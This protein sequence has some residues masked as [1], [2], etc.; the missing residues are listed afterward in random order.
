MHSLHLCILKCIYI[1]IRVSLV[2][3]R[4]WLNGWCTARRFQVQESAC[5]F[6]CEPGTRQGCNDSIEHYA[7][8]PVVRQFAHETLSLPPHTVGNVLGF[9]C[10]HA[11]IDCDTR[12]VQHLLLYAVYT[13]TNRLRR[14]A[15]GL[16]HY[17]VKELLLQYIHQGAGCNPTAQK[18]VRNCLLSAS[19]KRPRLAAVDAEQDGLSTDDDCEAECTRA[20]HRCFK[21]T[22]RSTPLAVTDAVARPLAEITAGTRFVQGRDHFMTTFL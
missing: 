19:S 15:A 17:S 5:L 9:L 16:D 7:H 6:R 3:L 14:C 11:N 22:L 10:L 1:Y 12:L 21:S 8:C 20:N 2:L 18:A 13:A 4:T